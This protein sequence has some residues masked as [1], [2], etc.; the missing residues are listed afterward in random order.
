MRNACVPS[1]I[2]MG[3][4]L[5]LS[6]LMRMGSH[7]P[8]EREC[9]N[10]PGQRRP[11]KTSRCYRAGLGAGV[12]VTKYRV[13]NPGWRGLARRPGGNRVRCRRSDPHVRRDA[14]R[15]ARELGI[16]LFRVRVGEFGAE[17]KYLG[18]LK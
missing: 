5:R 6:E 2:R 17:E 8:A 4:P 9:G 13:G 16:P 3:P 12:G 7:P 18:R 1:R 11:E 10:E 14:L 15:T